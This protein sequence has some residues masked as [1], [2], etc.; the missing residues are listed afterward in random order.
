VAVHLKTVGGVM[1]CERS[2]VLC[3]VLLSLAAAVGFK[4]LADLIRVEADEV[5]N[6]EVRN[7]VLR[8]QAAEVTDTVVEPVG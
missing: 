3:R 7:A 6:F 2:C 4:P 1:D 8:Y 5:T